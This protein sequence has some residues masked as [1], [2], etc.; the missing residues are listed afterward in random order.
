MD[1][2]FDF[3]ALLKNNEKKH[4]SKPLQFTSVAGGIQK[5]LE[6]NIKNRKSTRLTTFDSIRNLPVCESP[7]P[8]PISEAKMKM[9]HRRQQLE[10]WKAEKEQKKKEQAA[11]K[12]KPFITGVAK[13]TMKFEPPPPPPKPSTSGR[14][15]RSQTRTTKPKQK[16]SPVKPNAKSRSTQSFAPRNA[17][18]KPPEIKN[19]VKLPTLAPPSRT[20]NKASTITFDPVIPNAVTTVK[21][22]RNRPVLTRQ[23]AT[24]IKP[25]TANIAQS[26]TRNTRGKIIKLSPKKQAKKPLQSSSSS[27]LDAAIS[28]I[29]NPSRKSFNGPK[30]MAPKVLIMQSTSEDK[31]TSDSSPDQ[32]KRR[33]LRKCTYTIRDKS[34]SDKSSDMQSS[35]DEPTV[36]VKPRKSL[37]RNFSPATS[38]SDRISS[39]SDVE[40]IEEKSPVAKTTRKSVP[41][42]Q[43]NKTP[44]SVSSSA[45]DIEKSPVITTRKSLAVTPKNKVPKSESSSE[46]KLRSPRSPIELPLTPE[47]MESAKISPCVTMSRGKD[48]ARKEMKWKIDEGLLDDDV[49]DIDSVTHFRKQLSSEIKRMTEMC[50]TWDKISEQTVLPE[51]ISEQ[52]VLPEPVQEA[53]L[54]AVGQCRL[55]MSQKLQQFASL[56]ERCAKPEPGTA[57]VTPA[58]LHGFWDMVFMQVENV[59]LRFK[60]LEELRQRNWVED[61]P[62]PK[63]KPAAKPLAKKP[64]KPAGGAS[65]I[66]EMIAAARK[67][68]QT[69]PPQ[70]PAINIAAPSTDNEKTFHAGFF[71]V[72][73]PVRSPAAHSPCTPRSK[74]TLLKAVLSSEAKKASHSKNSTPFAMLRASILAK[75]AK[76]EGVAP[77]PQT[78]QTQHMPL[79]TP[80]R[81]ILKSAADNQKSAKKSLKVVLFDASDTDVSTSPL[82]VIQNKS[83]VYETA[84]DDTPSKTNENLAQIQDKENSPS[85][86][87]RPRTRNQRK[88]KN[89]SIVEDAQDV[90]PKET[91]KSSRKKK[92]D[93]EVKTPIRSSGRN[94]KSTDDVEVKSA[95]KKST[96]KAKTPLQETNVLEETVPT[97]K[98]STRRNRV[99]TVF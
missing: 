8:A 16:S 21:Q 40:I 14:V 69:Q 19:L 42:T 6:T 66:R 52:T 41:L 35:T 96:R 29:Q 57:L 22:A 44:K 73:S 2:S 54:S 30:H 71:S 11:N 67:A 70:S 85:P 15:T 37:P 74:P 75:N 72:R 86:E 1:K 79:A 55:L 27:D 17:T 60:A 10:K 82:S 24:E 59:D 3:G 9:E 84:L 34:S 83:D 51:P 5:R 76:C 23:N 97:P 77:L 95:S 7:G 49:S 80:G 43:K 89:S 56:V 63:K 25:S 46:E 62:V 98:R 61:K 18:F 50:D 36:V 91:R 45:S 99:S 28:Q 87:V 92:A 32:A 88:S 58:D 94:K 33:S 20:R 78:P 81:S 53:V 4:K 38:N 12:K 68:K 31:T 13:H 48:N 64:A 26:R 93:E 47:Q 65:R 90:A 39:A